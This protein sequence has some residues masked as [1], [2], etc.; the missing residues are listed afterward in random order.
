MGARKIREL[1]IVVTILCG[2]A[3]AAPKSITDSG[4][5]VELDAP[6]MAIWLPIWR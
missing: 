1:L 5:L 6:T 3:R 4:T 2:S